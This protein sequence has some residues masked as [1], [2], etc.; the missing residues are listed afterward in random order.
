MK[1]KTVLLFFVILV[2]C[3]AFQ[4]SADDYMTQFWGYTAA[5]T[6]GD[7]VKICSAVD[8]L[9]AALPSPRDANEHNK[10]IWAFQTAARENMKLENYDKALYYYRKFVSCAEWL[11]ANDAQHHEENITF[12]N[13]MINHL[14]LPSELY[15]ACEYPEDAVYYGAKNEPRYGVFNGTCNGFD[16]QSETAHLLYVRFFDETI[17]SFFYMLPDEDAYLLVAWNLPH[18]SR[19]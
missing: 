6:D 1:I 15:V 18:E 12:A 19:E 10:L 9:D 17:E 11:Q 14:E 16:T 5:V 4:V 2:F 13:A 7:P 3:T 8:A